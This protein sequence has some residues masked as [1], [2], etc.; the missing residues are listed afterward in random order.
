MHI[1]YIPENINLAGKLMFDEGV[2]NAMTERKTLVEW[3]P[4]SENSRELWSIWKKIDK[5]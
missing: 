2:V 5:T 1:S 4:E 3:D